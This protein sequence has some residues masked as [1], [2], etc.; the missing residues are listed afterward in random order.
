MKEGMIVPGQN[1]VEIVEEELSFYK[2]GLAESSLHPFFPQ[3]V[4]TISAK[5]TRK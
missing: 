3:S 5:T 4:P 2:P 1:A